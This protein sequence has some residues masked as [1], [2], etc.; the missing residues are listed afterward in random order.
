MAKD[1]Y[2]INQEKKVFMKDF[3]KTVKNMDSESRKSKTELPMKVNLNL[4][5]KMVR[6]KKSHPMEIF[7]K[8]NLFRE[9]SKKFLF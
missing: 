2:N 6:E 4:I 9:K 5:K 7:M 8:D 3:L 1:Y